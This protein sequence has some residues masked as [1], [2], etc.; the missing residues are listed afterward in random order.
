MKIGKIYGRVILGSIIVIVCIIFLGCLFNIN[1]TSRTD[2]KP[3]EVIETMENPD[4]EKDGVFAEKGF[5][6]EYIAEPIETNKYGFFFNET[7]VGKSDESGQVTH[8]VF[9]EDGS[10]QVSYI[11]EDWY[12]K[13]HKELIDRAFKVSNY[14]E[15]NDKLNEYYL[16]D[17]N[18]KKLEKVFS[19]KNLAFTDGEDTY[20]FS[21]DGMKIYSNPELT[22]MLYEVNFE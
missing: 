1:S 18:G 16:G 8:L 12:Y 14:G 19:Y 21:K 17:K 2:I 20:Y 13:S 22:D 6:K 9:S 15:A 5:V 3:T 11:F 10:Y 7:Y 4:E